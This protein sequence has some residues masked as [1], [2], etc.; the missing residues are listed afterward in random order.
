MSTRRDPP[1]AFFQATRRV[2]AAD[3]VFEQLAAALLRGEIAPGSSLPPERSLAEEFRTSRIIARQAIHRLAELGLVSVRQGGA[4]T[5]LDPDEAAD[6]RVLELVYRLAPDAGARSID[7]R[8]VLEKQLLQGVALVEVAAR[9]ASEADLTRLREM[10]EAFAA[11]DVDEDGYRTFE[12]RFW[13]AVAAAGGNRIFVME[14][15]WWYRV[16]AR[17]PRVESHAPSP[18]SRRVAFYREVARRLDEADAPVAFYLEAVAVILGKL[19]SRSRKKSP[20][21]RSKGRKAPR[22]RLVVSSLAA[23]ALL[24]G[25]GCTT[26]PIDGTGPTTESSDAGGDPESASD[27]SGAVNG[28]SS[29]PCTVDAVL[30]ANCRQCHGQTPSFGAPMPLVTY[31]DLWAPAHSNPAQRVY[32]VVE[33]R[34]HDDEHPMPQP[35]NPRLDS[36]DLATIDSWV[37]TGA[38]PGD[39][40]DSGTPAPDGGSLTSLPC[41]PDT[42][43]APASPWSMPASVAETYVCYGVDVNVA[44]KRQ[45]I[46]MAPRIDDAA[47]LH[48]VT[49]LEADSAVSPVPT[50]CPL[51]GSTSWR[52]VFGW[53]PGGS[54]FV[55]PPEAGF[56]ED[57]TTHFVVQL[58]YVNPLGKTG[59]TDASGFDLCTTDE[60]RP[61]D[62]DVMA[63]G[64]ED[65]SIPPNATV[66][67]TCD[68]PVPS[69]GATTH[70]F[71]AFPHMHELGRSI[72]TTAFP[73]DGGSVDLGSQ[74]NWNFG[75]QGWIPIS[76]VLAPGDVVETRCT[77]V[78]TTDQTVGFG[79]TTAD[80]MCFSFT[81]YYP[82]ITD[83]AWNW[84]LPAL[85][86][87]CH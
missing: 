34:I 31:A 26:T 51:S 13:R 29:L 85:Y 84:A 38:P 56:P 20:A 25:T 40:C 45:I 44:S 79:E 16:L 52:P 17:H 61:N 68:V 2:H 86:S 37:S 18:L 67:E 33:Q 15:A 87:T 12:E 6:L 76:D 36:A 3:D 4:T 73:V 48:H 30:A 54:S 24:A 77:W 23:L 55:L 78:N 64:T 59:A 5:V 63:F 8:Q 7:A 35:P 69:Y 53:A 75:E 82:K 58:H 46:A 66:T 11:G 57:A 43:I 42:H 1:P 49:L 32:Q 39:A 9:C 72:E 50:T 65:I 41:V 71:A 21:P 10:T 62:A 81:M 14:V 28:A 70:L 60:L 80:E 47:I 27:A 22:A 74:P 83:P 19:R